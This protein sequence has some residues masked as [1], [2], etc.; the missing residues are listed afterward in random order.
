MDQNAANKQEL[1]KAL[2][3]KRLREAAQKQTNAQSMILPVQDGSIVLSVGQERLWFLD[4]WTPGNSSYNMPVGVRIQGELDANL[5]E[6]AL[7]EIV[8]RHQV[9]RTGVAAR[10]GVPALVR[11]SEED[12]ECRFQDVRH[13]EDRDALVQ[14][15]IAEEVRKPFQLSDHLMIRALLL[16]AD[17]LEHTLVL[18]VHH[19][20]A[21]GWSLG[22]LLREVAALYEA[23]KAGKPSPL[24]D[25]PIQYSDY[26]AWQRENLDSEEMSNHVAYWKKQLQG[27]PA[28]L[29]LPT[30][31]A[32]PLVQTGR[33]GSLPFSLTKQT[34]SSL[35]A[36]GQQEQATLFM[37][38]LAAFKLLMSRLSGQQD[39]V[40][41]M[42]VAG[43]NRPELEGLVGF[44]VN[45]LALRTDFS[46]VETFRD[47]VRKVRTSMLGS[48]DHQTVPFEKLVDEL[49]VQRDSS[50]NPIYQVIMSYNNT[51]MPSM[52][53]A[54]L[55]L[56]PI[57]VET[58]TS[59]VDLTMELWES[60]DGLEGRL[61]Y[62]SD[63]FE[64]ETAERF[65]GHFQTLLQNLIAQPDV[66]LNEVKL[67]TEDEQEELL[68]RFQDNFELPDS[69]HCLH[70]LFEEQVNLRPESVAL[71]YETE[72][73]TYR[74]LNAR[75]NRLAHYLK[76][77][78]V[79]PDSLV[80]LYLERSAEMIVAILGVLK[81]GGAYVPLDPSSPNDRV[82]FIMEDASAVLMLTQTRLLDKLPS[83]GL[84]LVCL[85]QPGI[86]DE[87]PDENPEGGAQSNHLAYV[88]YTSGSTGLPK[89]VMIEHRQAV[90]LFQATE[91]WYHFDERDVWT[92]FHSYAFDFSVWEI[93]GALL[94]GGRLVVVPYLV[95]RN[96]EQF[97]ELLAREQVTMLSQTPSAF[98]QL[99]RVEENRPELADAL[100]LR[101][102]VFGGEALEFQSLRPW[103]ERHGDQQPQLVN[104]Y[105]ITETTVHVTYRP[106]TMQDVEE[107]RGSL[108]GVPIPDLQLYILDD[109]L[110]P[111]PYG[112]PGEMFI[113]GAGVAR[114]YLNRPEL[115]STRYLPNPFR[116]GGRLYRSGDLARR[117]SN[118]DIEYMGRI[119][120]QVKVRGF[121]IEL[122]EIESQLSQHP[123]IRECVVLV[124]EEQPGDKRLIAYVVPAS[125]KALTITEM[126]QFLQQELPEYMIPALFVT[127]DQM[128]LTNNGK[129]DR[130]ALLQL[131]VVKSD[132][133]GEY[134][135]PTTP[136]Q[137]ALA[138]IF[139]E[140]LQLERVGI[141]DN[142]FALGGDSI[143]A[144]RVVARAKEQ[145]LTFN[146]QQL[147]QH[148]SVREL[149]EVLQVGAQ[150]LE[151]SEAELPVTEPFHGLLESD[152]QLLP[153]GVEDAYPLSALQTGMFFHMEYNEGEATYYN[154]TTL[155]IR[156]AFDLAKLET[157][158]NRVIARH[159]ALRTGFDFTTFSEPLQ[160]V[161]AAAPLRIGLQDLRHLNTAEQEEHFQ[162]WF[163]EERTKTFDYACP[164]LIR[165]FVHLRSDNLFEFSVTECHAILDGWSLTS[166]F[167]EIFM[168]Y[169]AQL[170]D[171]EF[172]EPE[173]PIVSFRDFVWWERQA[174][175]SVDSRDFWMKKID[176][177]KPTLLPR[178]SSAR[179]D[180]VERTFQRFLT[181]VPREIQRGLQELSQ[182][183]GVPLKSVLLAAHVKVLSLLA[184]D[185]DVQT[186]LTSNGRSEDRGGDRVRG[187]FLNT[188][189]FRFQLQNGTWSD[190]VRAVFHDEM[191]ILP[192]RR[193]P[194]SALQSVYGRQ[195]LFETSFNFVHFHALKDVVTNGPMEILDLKEVADTN[196]NLC[197]TFSLLPTTG[198]LILMLDTNGRVV[199]PEQGE[200]MRGY[201]LKVLRT[202][203]QQP[204]TEHHSFDPLSDAERRQLLVDFNDT[205]V[206]YPQDKALHLLFE[207]QAER[208]PDR[209][210]LVFEDQVL[211]YGELNRRA[212]QLAH[213]LQKLGVQKEDLV[214]VSME[215]SMEMVISL[216]AILKAGGAYVPI[217]PT[218][219]ADRLSYMLQDARVP[220]LLTQ[221]QLLD[222][223]DL[224]SVQLLYLD[225]EATA[226]A[227]KQE[228]DV[229]PP[230]TTTGEN[231]AYMIYTSGST[232]MPKGVINTH[233]GIVNRL[234]W[235]QDEYNLT[236][237][238]TVLQKTPFSFDV[239][240]WEFFWPLFTG[241]RLV[242]ARPEGHRDSAYLVELIQRE[243]VTT[244]HFVPSMLQ[245]FLEEQGVEACRSLRQVM[246]SGEAL[247]AELVERFFARLDA[248]LHNLYGP[249]E[250]AVDVTYWECQPNT[251][252]LLVPIGRPVANTQ[253]YILNGRMQPVPIGVPGEL[254]IG[255]IQVAR[256][257]HNRPELT[258]EKFIADPFLPEGRLY[259]TGDLAR[260]MPDG[261]IQYLGRIDHQVKIRGLRI[262]L[263]EIEADLMNLPEVRA[264][265]VLA[266]E[267][268]PGDKRLVAYVVVDPE[269]G[270]TAADMRQALL[271]K[272][273]DYMVPSAFI[274]LDAIPLSPNG[275]VDRR[276]LP[277][278][279]WSQSSQSEYA[280]PRTPLEQAVAEI[281]AN[282]L[283]LER[284]SVEDNFFSLGGHSLLATQAISRLKI[285]LNVHLPLRSLFDAP[286]ARLLAAH[287]EGAKQSAR[288]PIIQSVSSED[289]P[290]SFAQQRLWLME[291]LVPGTALYNMPMAVRLQGELQIEALVQSLNR[292]VAR[293]EALRT[294]FLERD[295]RPVQVIH[296]TE[297]M[298]FNR[299]DLR[300]EKRE[301]RE[302]KMKQLVQ[303]EAERPFDLQVGPL[304]R[305]HLIQLAETEHVLVLNMHHIVSDG[306]SLQVLIREFVA[307]YEA[308]AAGV[309]S[310]LPELPIQYRNYA[311]WQREWLQGDVLEEQMSYWKEQ[312]GGE[313]PVLQLPTDR[314]HPSAQ[315][316]RG[317][318]ES[319]T[320]PSELTQELQALSRRHGT[321]MFMTLL[322]AFQLLL[323]RYSG[324]EDI[325]VG[326]PIAGRHHHDTEQL[327]GF[328]VNTLVMRTDLSGAP[329]FEELLNRVREV[330]LG[331]YAHQDVP[332]EKLVEELQPERDLS[333]S[334]LFQV[335]FTMQDPL[336]KGIELPGLTLAAVEMDTQIAKFDLT[337]S[338]VEEGGALAGSL[339]Y[340]ADLF[341]AATVQRMAGHITTLL[342]SI[343]DHPTS[344]VFELNYLTEEERHQL[345]VEF[346]RTMPDQHSKDA[347]LHHVFDRQAERVPNHIALV[348]EQEELTYSQ[349]RERADRVASYLHRKGVQPE[350][351]VG[352]M[353]DRSPNAI[354]ALLGILKAG[355]VYLPLDPTYPRER[356]DYM[357]Q[358]SGVR[359][360][361]SQGSLVDSFDSSAFEV[362]DIDVAL[363]DS[364]EITALPQTHA[365]QAAYIIYTSGSTGTPK[366]VV[367]EHSAVSKH[368]QTVQSHYEITDEDIVL[369]FASLNFDASLEQ[370]FSALLSGATVFLRGNTLWSAQELLTNLHKFRVS[371]ANVPT[372]YW[373]QV[374]YDWKAN[375]AEIPPSLRLMIAGGEALL[376]R[377][378]EIWREL[379][380]EK[381][382]LLNAYGP[383]ET[384]ITSHAY[385]ISPHT[386]LQQERAVPI[387]AALGDRISYVL[388]QQ[389]QPVPIGVPGELHIGGSVLAR[390]YVNQPELTAKKFVPNPY[391]DDP[392][393]RLYKTGDLV[394]YLPDGQLEYLGRID[395]QVKIRGFRI[396]LGEI[397]AALLTRQDVEQA[398][399]LIREDA[400]GD[401][402]IIAYV[403]AAE[404]ASPRTEE[405]LQHL[406]Q[407]LPAY[408][409]PSA[410]MILQEMPLLPN[411]KVDRRALPAP[412]KSQGNRDTYAAPRIP[413]EE[414]VAKIFAEVLNLERVSAEADFFL[415]GGHSLLATQAVSRLKNALD[416][417]LPLRILFESPT[418]RSLAARISE[419]KQ[420][421]LVSPKPRELVSRQSEFPLSFAQQRLWIIEQLTP[422][423]SLYNMPVAVRLQGDLHLDALV[424]SLQEIV[425]RHEI[426][427]TTFADREGQSVQIIHESSE[428]SV[429]RTDLRTESPETRELKMQQLVSSE[430]DQPFD[431]T[432]GSLIRFH[433]IQL[434][435]RE[436]VLV[437]NMH[438][439]V[440]DGWSLQVLIREFVTLYEAFAAGQPSPL[441]DLTMQYADYAAWQRDWLQGEVLQEQLSYWKEK[442]GGELPVLQLPTDRPHPT[443]QTYR[444]AD[445]RFTLSAELTQQ[446]QPLSRRHGA[447][448]FMTLLSAFQLLLSRYSGQEDITVG[449]PIAG[450]TMEETEGL[451]GFFVNTLVMRTDLSGAPTFEELLGRVRET[452]LG[453]YSHQ[454]IPF[455]KLVEE[456]KPERD[457]SRSPLFQV[458][459]S[460]QSALSTD[461]ELPGLTITEVEMNSQV[462]KFDLT[463]TLVEEADGVV[464]NLAYNVDLFDAATIQR[465]VGH[466]TTL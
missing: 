86:F 104:M 268:K 343:V 304:I 74:E 46:D 361:I 176:D 7:R 260:F 364:A 13:S 408:M 121:R 177:C 158:V 278:P 76:A 136:E 411:G 99:I 355:G 328:F 209:V 332:F 35:Q 134:V 287:L 436:H 71:V 315:T 142:Y 445:E 448:M 95:S 333:R 324:Q 124:R 456:L 129:V 465:M 92:V 205:H 378:V 107:G 42:P 8:R 128:P 145:G 137:Q 233:R 28:R 219:P 288:Q 291:Q 463:L 325:S 180:K 371:V 381:V 120:N 374:V 87:Q 266:R 210:A 11:G 103:F 387:G 314:P 130:R 41:G 393:A 1:L 231:A 144:L 195:S 252:Q 31:H 183:A 375:K 321:T 3:E 424:R 319:F 239:S 197:S 345:L 297:E 267:D 338:M 396:E 138:D 108:I 349:L 434:H 211:T 162:Q 422:G 235:M 168:L 222:H 161:H 310:P 148:Q 60:A 250:A 213:H 217:D 51:P 356:L 152:V 52:S 80:G 147:F 245:V 401:K 64:A 258:A 358:D 131:T 279:E 243:R 290:L 403:V 265:V 443:L 322:G 317:A 253:I 141:D 116:G 82:S 118:G 392:A 20:A 446:L 240:V 100:A 85:D 431:L 300:K 264:A 90:R 229:N 429:T 306:W 308:F 171:E 193:Y 242:V 149:C 218:Y 30:D 109:R 216:Y 62:C 309:P 54:G 170:Q 126:R 33:G 139:A 457:L 466:F 425:V 394:R 398:A 150:A 115:T 72:A 27:A 365:N 277:V 135:A 430:I 386:H 351:P 164:P 184:G 25:L 203:A 327:I 59:K 89:G 69:Q 189:P 66:V 390:G 409:A 318:E 98:R 339:Q 117:L 447:T 329:T 246:C 296:E 415:M 110:Q 172:V 399:V 226:A 440:S 182:K 451:I 458:M 53:F 370:L 357:I 461:L 156:A 194:L 38:L 369:Q 224:S 293:H 383:T 372:A 346:T 34:V 19:I 84:T 459:F 271:Q 114:G 376:S 450:R 155:S 36:L 417:Q 24:A 437:L 273:P 326:T 418:V 14:R 385:E 200:A 15:L 286:T 77:Q 270:M 181:H 232:G 347:C 111:V 373:Q 190:L 435:E 366:G 247:P 238:D 438:H 311:A 389:G 455:E 22:V 39:V 272:L 350:E 236:E 26:A 96:P 360:V 83:Q 395:N 281:F 201:F 70:Q 289:N 45:T 75:A 105:G 283:Q 73:L 230:C 133:G 202:M 427:R 449:T 384:V 199:T 101:F 419:M 67:L 106:V 299:I 261:T 301:D 50:Y 330:A 18:T 420:G 78:G 192:H 410:I 32:R 55:S 380:T 331:A 23:M 452:A 284:V 359:F 228:S 405:I 254:H 263:G 407:Q 275:K 166:I 44:F 212:N 57:R 43:R 388:D 262:E 221:K 303:L 453:A 153:K 402:R 4:Q 17:E 241:A 257:Y 191:E 428:I 298:S 12:F 10:E 354:L 397:E 433:L 198:E 323:S 88:I 63:L 312:L 123:D 363:A 421:E 432:S 208:T 307:L 269:S 204:E 342:K 414:T 159:P 47:L 442:L 178:W 462:A 187:L 143:R 340:N 122:G 316:Y 165:I 352:M 400:P 140:V 341:D 368:V 154:I 125:G 151:E 97:Y 68:Y 91:H 294:V 244:L 276:A 21:D 249:T 416:V 2:K 412:E 173:A 305:A 259:K 282:L 175:Q 255:G 214:G 280:A 439:I 29:E 174:L 94:Y 348:S 119:D 127:L 56:E 302:Q 337:L 444:G 274:L 186:G 460:M 157:A 335:M 102:V 295:G 5:L 169:L 58:E 256:L 185:D 93:W 377:P 146:L 6:A 16:R 362:V 426:L 313:L 334:P 344:S 167:S 9:L 132:F 382:R 223:L 320:L 454:D 81:A 237:Q 206:E 220:L 423:T 207:E 292:I 37:M 379:P 391:S 464:G 215:R 404:F 188:L 225:D 79:G 179:E 40:I 367:V 163:A 49:N 248:R 406:Q 65:L 112:V 196:F 413:L 251:G 441:A 234:L 61:E 113:G 336:S 353:L 227:L 48:L 160:L 285:A